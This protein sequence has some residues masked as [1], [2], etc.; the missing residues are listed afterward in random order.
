MAVQGITQTSCTPEYGGTWK[1][2]KVQGFV[3]PYT[4]LFRGTGLLGTWVLLPINDSMG[5]TDIVCRRRHLVN[6]NY[7]HELGCHSSGWWRNRWWKDCLSC[8]TFLNLAKWVNLQWGIVAYERGWHPETEQAF[9]S[10]RWLSASFC[11]DSGS[12]TVETAIFVRSHFFKWLLSLPRG[13]N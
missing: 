9:L 7:Q 12:L 4:V 10:T 8:C 1:Y 3:P 6:E 11:S 5:G 2:I 13:A